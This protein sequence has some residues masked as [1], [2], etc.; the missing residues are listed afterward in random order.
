MRSY[1]LEAGTDLFGARLA[2]VVYGRIGARGRRI[3]YVLPD[4]GEDSGNTSHKKAC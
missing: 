3:R 1:R 4:V 2:D